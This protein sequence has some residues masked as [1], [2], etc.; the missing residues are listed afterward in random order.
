MV[1]NHLKR[2]A[3]S[4]NWKIQKKEEKYVAKPKPGSHS[5]EYGIPL[6]L[7]LRDLLKIGKTRK[8]IRDIL[9]HQEVLV[10][11]KQTKD[12][13]R[14]V[15]L[16]DTISF[17]KIKKNYRIILDD[18]GKLNLIEIDEKEAKIK[19]NK[20]KGKVMVG[21]K[22]QLNLFDGRNILV[23]KTDVK[24]KATVAIEVPTQKI[25]EQFNFEKGANILLTGGKHIGTVGIVESV[26]GNKLVFKNEKNEV[27]ETIKTHAYVVG[28]GKTYVKIK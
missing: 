25:L 1:K 16:M 19:L 13:K 5:M 24:V 26:E 27:F 9:H 15:G 12:H 21:K 4:K 3:T 22:I 6:V 17:P 8:E 11:G 14:M 10:D 2:I 18:R 23:E 20:V 28:K 7:A